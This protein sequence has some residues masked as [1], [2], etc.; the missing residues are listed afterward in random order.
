M[1]ENFPHFVKDINRH[2]PIYSRK[3]ANPKQDQLKKIHD[4][5]DQTTENKRQRKTS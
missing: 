4:K 5:K 1:T 2:Q 3:S